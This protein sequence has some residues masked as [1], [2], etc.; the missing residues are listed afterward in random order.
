MSL[1]VPCGIIAVAS[2]PL[3][4]KLVPPNGVYG[5]RTKQTLSSPEIWFR[6]NRFAGCALFV[7][8]AITAAIFAFRPEYASGRELPGLAALLVPLVMAVVAS[9]SYVRAIGVKQHDDG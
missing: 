4:L 3:M 6:A 7:S 9:F 5:F 8:S 2:V 1:F